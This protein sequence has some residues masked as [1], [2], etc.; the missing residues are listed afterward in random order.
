MLKFFRNIRKSLINSGNARKYTLYA[1]GEIALVVIGI[2]IALQ[3]NNWNEN[4]FAAVC[5][6]QAPSLCF[7][8]VT[9]RN[10]KKTALA[11]RAKAGDGCLTGFEP[12]TSRTTI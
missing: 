12:A 1:I 2:L 8:I 4:P 11:R 9:D 5:E 7:C 6:R 10:N 3:L